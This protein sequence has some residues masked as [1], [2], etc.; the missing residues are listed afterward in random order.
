[1]GLDMS[2]YKRQEWDHFHSIVKKEGWN[3]A[4]DLPLKELVYWRRAY[5]IHFWFC[6]FGE[7]RVDQTGYVVTREQLK[8]LLSIC[9]DYYIGDK[10]YEDF[11]NE[12]DPKFKDSNYYCE[13]WSDQLKNTIDG[14][15][16]CLFENT[17]TEFVYHASW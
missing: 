5:P 6:S 8:K 2:I 10:L 14:L 3:A 17:D 4:F 15:L 9:I 11:I 13:P 12:I 16:Q 7:K 1:M